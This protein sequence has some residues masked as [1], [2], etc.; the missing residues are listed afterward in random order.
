MQIVFVLPDGT[1]RGITVRE[2]M[3]IMAAATSNGIGGI[4]GECGGNAMCATCHVYISDQRLPSVSEE[5]DELLEGTADERT[6]ESRLG[7]QIRLTGD[8]DGLRVRLPGRQV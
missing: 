7:C 5:E 4:V 3:S 6:L 8:L 1:E 2:G